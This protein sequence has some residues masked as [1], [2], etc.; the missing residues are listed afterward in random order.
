MVS[1]P[2]LRLFL[3]LAILERVIHDEREVVTRGLL[4]L[5]RVK[6]VFLDEEN[7]LLISW[8]STISQLRT[9]QYVD[10]CA[11]CVPRSLL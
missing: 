5:E 6:I 10:C 7:T 3:V 9:K 1:D 2:A 8:E 4:V 11:A